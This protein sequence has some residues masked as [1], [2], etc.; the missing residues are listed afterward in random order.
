M[1]VHSPRFDAIWSFIEGFDAASDG[2]PLRGFREWLLLQRGSFT[3]LCWF[4]L[5]RER[6]FPDT[7]PGDFPAE[8][9]HEALRAELGRVL[10]A[11]KIA[12]ESVG[13]ERI[14]EGYQPIWDAA[15][16]DKVS[17]S[18]HCC[19]DMADAVN[20]RCQ[21]HPERHQCPDALLEFS[22]A[23]NAYGLMIH[24][25]GSSSRS[26]SFC[27]FCGSRLPVRTDSD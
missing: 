9:E 25:G 15:N 17:E 10:R 2:E 20:S 7:D 3:N 21:E 26:I 18:Q 27:P 11:F 16:T 19:S 6:V 13:L 1:F 24:D 12:R 22:A 5:I 14:L 4:M 8:G 23:S